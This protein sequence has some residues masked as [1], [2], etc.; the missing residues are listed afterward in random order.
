MDLPLAVYSKQT[1]HNT[2]SD[3][4]V[5]ARKLIAYSREYH[6]EL[7][8]AS[9]AHCIAMAAGKLIGEFGEEKE[10]IANSAMKEVAAKWVFG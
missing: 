8:T 3:F 7:P 10:H 2:D 6:E 1:G 5:Y 4:S 9:P